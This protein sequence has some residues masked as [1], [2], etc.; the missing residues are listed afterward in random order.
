MT[1]FGSKKDNFILVISYFL[2][3]SRFLQTLDDATFK[4]ERDRQRERWRGWENDSRRERTRD[5]EDERKTVTQ[6][7]W[8]RKTVMDRT[9]EKDRQRDSERGQER[10]RQTEQDSNRWR[11]R[12][13]ERECKKDD[14]K[15]KERQIQIRVSVSRNVAWNTRSEVKSRRVSRSGARCV[16]RVN[17]RRRSGAGLAGVEWSLV[18]AN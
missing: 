2:H 16:E 4:G 18:A 7:E 5:E 17:R 13:T 1:L 14:D 6:R 10:E 8:Q 3:Y 15:E 9:R 12:E 11:E